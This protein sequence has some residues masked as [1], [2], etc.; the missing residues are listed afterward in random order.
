[1]NLFKYGLILQTFYNSV[2]FKTHYKY[3]WTRLDIVFLLNVTLSNRKKGKKKKP[4]KKWSVT[5]RLDKSFQ[6][7]AQCC[8]TQNES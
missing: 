8:T 7:L 5:A 3:H 4:A 1:M 2:V 6:I